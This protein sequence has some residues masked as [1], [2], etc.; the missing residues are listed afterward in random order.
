MGEITQKQDASLQTQTGNVLGQVSRRDIVIPKLYPVQ[1]MAKVLED[2]SV[3]AA[4]GDFLDNLNNDKHGDTEN[5]VEIIPFGF[6]KKWVEYDRIVA[7]NGSV[8][9]E[10]KQ[11]LPIT[12]ENDQLPYTD[13][14][15]LVERDRVIDLYCLLPSQI[16]EGVGFPYVISFRRTSLKAGNKVLTQ[17]LRNEMMGKPTWA[18]TMKISGR[19]TENDDGAYIVLD[20]RA[21]RLTTEEESQ[22]CVKWMQLVNSGAAKVQED[23]HTEEAPRK[24]VNA[25][26][27][28]F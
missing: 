27:S 9:R 5:P 7:K 3:E 19:V 20:A 4:F 14:N 15:G 13:E 8:K 2:K 23:D 21:G 11:V 18:V 10:Y 22:E 12:P 17:L 6:Q 25:S 16:E 28:E 1:K 24:D 26:D